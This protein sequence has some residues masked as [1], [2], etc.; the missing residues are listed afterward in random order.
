MDVQIIGVHVPYTEEERS[1]ETGSSHVM[2]NGLAIPSSR[3]K[4]DGLLL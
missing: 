4:S 1:V 2:D 3:A